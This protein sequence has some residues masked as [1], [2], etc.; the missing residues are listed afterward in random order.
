MK[1][2]FIL[3]NTRSV[4]PAPN[5]DIEQEPAK[6]ETVVKDAGNASFVARCWATKKVLI[7][8][9]ALIIAGV[10]GLSIFLGV[11][12]GTDDDSGKSTGCL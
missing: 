8:A 1:S 3:N 2:Q 12:Y 11:Y 10:V 7:I 5:V 6:A 4:S 9:G